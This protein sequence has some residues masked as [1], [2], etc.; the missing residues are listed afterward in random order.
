MDVL[1]AFLNNRHELSKV[2]TDPNLLEK[3]ALNSD[4]RKHVIDECG[5]TNNY[6][7]VI[8]DRFKRDGVIVDGRINPKYIPNVKEDESSF[9]L[10]LYFDLKK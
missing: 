9:K 6:M 4:S 1:A 2:I 7:Q 10:L 3:V 5:I 8:M